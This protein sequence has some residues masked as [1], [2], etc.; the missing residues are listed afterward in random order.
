MAGPPRLMLP[1]L[2]GCLACGP[3]VADDS[4]IL[5]S[6][7]HYNQ[8]GELSVYNPDGSLLVTLDKTRFM[9][10]ERKDQ[11][12]KRVFMADIDLPPDA[13]TGWYTIKVGT[14]DGRELTARDFVVMSRLDRVRITRP[15]DGAEDIAMPKHLSWEGVPGA[16]H[17]QVYLRDAWTNELLLRSKLL[18]SPEVALPDGKLEPGGFYYWTIHARDVNEHI[19]L[20]DFHMGSM[21][22]KHY[23]SVAE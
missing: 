2:A 19:L 1:L 12:T 20:G 8:L 6:D 4:R 3:V 13:A 21:S 15:P 10:L 11:P 7:P 23:F 22:E 5:E 17:Y 16:G 9:T 14:T 18:D